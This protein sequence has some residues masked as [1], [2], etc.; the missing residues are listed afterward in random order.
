MNILNS[1]AVGTTPIHRPRGTQSR[2]FTLIELL[3]VIAIIAILAGMLLPALGKAKSKTQGIQCMNNGRQMMMAWRLYAEDHQDL[4]VESLEGGPETN[5]RPLLVA[6]SASDNPTN[7]IDKSPLA[8]YLGNTR[9]VWKCPSDRTTRIE[10]G[11][12]LLRVRSQSMSQV[13]DYG[14]WL[15]SPPYR[16]YSRLAHIVNPTQTWVLVDE[17]PDSINDAACAVQMIRPDAKTGNIIDFPA[18]YHNGAAGFSFADGHSEIHRWVGGKIKTF[19]RGSNTGLNVPAGDS[20]IDAKWWSSVTTVG[21]GY[22]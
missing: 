7:T 14:G 10:G 19:G 9:E 12:K 22:E 11:R 6:G 16:T 8:K 17:H 21:P 18:A 5:L 1:T 4:L 15:P 13:F 3:V 2:G 20:L